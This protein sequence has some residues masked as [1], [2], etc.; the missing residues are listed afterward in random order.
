MFRAFDLSQTQANSYFLTG[1]M[2]RR[3]LQ[4]KV[5]SSSTGRS[6]SVAYGDLDHFKHA[7]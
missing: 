2:T 6:Y 1:L 7:E 4:T 3:S 5:G